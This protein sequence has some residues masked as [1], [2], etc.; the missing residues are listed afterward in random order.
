MD[1]KAGVT[2]LFIPSFIFHRRNPLSSKD[3][4]T[5]WFP[6]ANQEEH[7][8]SWSAPPQISL[9]S[10]VAK[11][12]ALACS[13]HSQIPFLLPLPSETK[14]SWQT[15][16]RPVLDGEEP[17]TQV[18]HRNTENLVWKVPRAGSWT[19]KSKVRSSKSGLSLT[20]VW[21]SSRRVI[22]QPLCR[23]CPVLIRFY[24]GCFFPLLHGNFPCQNLW[25]L[26]LVT[27][28]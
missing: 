24:C 22:S 25:P 2:L 20:D 14:Q 6:T 15:Y 18:L 5:C 19:S 3:T 11:R 27:I 9:P 8:E 13:G 12:A 1:S 23:V 17:S 16:D 26:P 21:K 28:T 10:C 7:K 4:N